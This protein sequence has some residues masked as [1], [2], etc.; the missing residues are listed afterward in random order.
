VAEA[1]IAINEIAP[2]IFFCNFINSSQYLLL[3]YIFLVP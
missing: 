1:I 2:V 3:K